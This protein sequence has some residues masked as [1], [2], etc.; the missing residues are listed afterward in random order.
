M[1]QISHSS[2]PRHREQIAISLSVRDR[3]Q[4][5]LTGRSRAVLIAYYK[6]AFRPFSP[7]P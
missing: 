4:V 2:A 7:L 3:L 5:D 6:T 1:N